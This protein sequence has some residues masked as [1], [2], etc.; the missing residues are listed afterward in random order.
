VLANQERELHVTSSRAA[1]S[2]RKNA[3]RSMHGVDQGCRVLVLV[4]E[5]R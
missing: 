5:T 3:Q 1:S 2:A 4:I